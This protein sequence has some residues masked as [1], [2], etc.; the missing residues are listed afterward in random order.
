MFLFVGFEH[1][2]DTIDGLAG[3]DR[4]ERAQHQMAC[5]GRAQGNLD[6]IAI[7]HFA[8]ENDLGRLA[9]GGPQA[10][11]EAVEVGA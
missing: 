5:L 7:A 2:E 11:R 3:I 8:H 10:V 9:Q 4:V 1:T 6:G